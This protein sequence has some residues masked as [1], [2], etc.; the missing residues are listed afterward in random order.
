MNLR[1]WTASLD[2]SAKA[3]ASATKGNFGIQGVVE[4]F[5]EPSKK[6]EDSLKRHFNSNTRDLPSGLFSTS[7]RGVHALFEP[8]CIRQAFARVDA[9]LL[10]VPRLLSAHNAFREL[11]TIPEVDQMRFYLDQLCPDTLHLLIYLYFRR[12]DH[13]IS[14]VSLTLH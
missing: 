5:R 11:S 1:A 3:E 7:A 14:K 10:S 12:L 13:Y 4:A 2:G 8:A 6:L 9:G